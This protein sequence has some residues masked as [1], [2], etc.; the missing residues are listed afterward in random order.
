MLQYY[1]FGI[2]KAA[3]AEEEP[4]VWWTS[5][6]HHDYCLFLHS[7]PFLIQDEG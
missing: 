7:F 1:R 3:R 5:V 4:L 6:E 2:E